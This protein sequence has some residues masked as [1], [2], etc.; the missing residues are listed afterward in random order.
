MKSIYLSLICLLLVSNCKSDQQKT[1]KENH[2]EEFKELSIAEK[3]ANAHGFEQWQNVSEVKFT[4]QVNRDSVQGKGRSWTWN[5]KENKVKMSTSETPIAY[6]RHKIDSSYISTDKAFINDKFWLLVPFQLVWDS[7]ATISEPKFV[8]SPIYNKTLKLITLTYPQKGGYTPGDAYDIYYD[9]DYIIREW[10]YRK[11]NSEEP[12]L[13]T[14]FENY[15][16]Y[17]GIKIAT[18]HKMEGGNWNLNFT[19][20]KI[21]LDDQK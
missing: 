9:D 13:S 14:T 12:S 17:N 8:T 16:D 20:V 11:G 2:K 1:S 3:I 4:F 7:T 5:P 21:T 15:N 6:V 10:A 18:D 19:A